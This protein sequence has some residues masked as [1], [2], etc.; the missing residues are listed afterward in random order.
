MPLKR[1]A[2]CLAKEPK[3]TTT[4]KQY[5]GVYPRGSGKRKSSYDDEALAPGRKGDPQLDVVGKTD[6]GA[7]IVAKQ[8]I[9]LCAG[10]FWHPFGVRLVAFWC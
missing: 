7:N 6:K 5:H 2:I 10:F 4:N 8:F 3:K 1:K 9:S